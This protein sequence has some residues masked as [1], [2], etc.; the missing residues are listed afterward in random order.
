MAHNTVC[1]IET[2]VKC[3]LLVHCHPCLQN[4]SALKP[5][6]WARTDEIVQPNLVILAHGSW[7]AF[8]L[9]TLWQDVRFSCIGQRPLQMHVFEIYN[10]LHR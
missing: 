4:P 9:R 10:T 6:A 1:D 3:S 2:K 8:D 7:I 5:G